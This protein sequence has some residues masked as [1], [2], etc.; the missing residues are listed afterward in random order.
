MACVVKSNVKG[1]YAKEVKDR[2]TFVLANERGFFWDGRYASACADSLALDAK[3]LKRLAV[4]LKGLLT[5][6]QRKTEPRGQEATRRLTFFV[7]SLLMDLPPPPPLDAAVSLTTLTPF[8]SED[9][10]LSEAD[11][12]KK[13]SDGVTTLLYLQTLYKADWRAFLE[14]RGIDDHAAREMPYLAQ[15]MRQRRACGPRS[16]PKRWRGRSRAS[17]RTKLLYGC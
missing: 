2:L 5:T 14:R 7:N 13:N 12:R 9:V 16:G 17:C 8:Y 3:L 10:I 1:S 4:K 11:L 15:S 6:P